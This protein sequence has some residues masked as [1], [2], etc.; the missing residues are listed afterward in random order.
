MKI[1][2]IIILL[3][4][5][6]S[7][8]FAQNWLDFK[9]PE[10]IKDGSGYSNFDQ[11]FG[12]FEDNQGNLYHTGYFD[13]EITF[14]TSTLVSKGG[15]DIFVAKVNKDGG[16]LWAVSAGG[17]STDFARDIACDNSGNIFITGYFYGTCYF[18]MIELSSQA[19]SDVFVA[20]INSNGE[21]QW[22]KSGNGSGFNRAN[23]ITCDN[24]G[25]AY[26]TGSFEANITFGNTTLS[27]SGNRDIFVVK[28]NSNGNFDWV[29]KAGGS[30]QDES[31]S[32][33]YNINNSFAMITGYFSTTAN[34]GNLSVVSAGGRDVYVARIGSN[35]TWAW[36]ANVGTSGSEEARAIAVDGSGNGIV[37][38]FYT[39]AIAFGAN[40]LPQGTERDIFVAKID[41]DGAWNWAA[42]GFGAGNDEPNSI[43]VDNNGNAYVV[44][45]F[46]DKVN[47][48]NTELTSTADRN[49]FVAR[50][51][52]SG[53]WSWGRAATGNSTIE[54]GG[55]SVSSTG[56]CC[57]SGSFYSN[58][59]I[60]NNTYNTLGESDIFVA[61]IAANGTWAWG[62]TKGG[63][64]GIT[65]GDGIAIDSIGNIIYTGSFFGKIKIGNTTLTSNGN[66]DIYLA[67]YSVDNGWLW[68]K[69]F[70]GIN[71]D[72]AKSI[73]TD[74]D[75]NIYLTG[76]FENSIA[77]GSQNLTSL[78][79][80]DAFIA[81]FD[82]QG[83]CIWANSIG[84]EDNDFGSEVILRDDF[85][86]IS[87]VYTNRPY[88]GLTRLTNRGNEDVYLS[89]MSLDGDYEWA[90]SLGSS[91]YETVNDLT[92]DAD[93][94]I[95]ITG[96]FE[97]NC[98]FGNI[99]TSSKGGDDVYI[100][101]ASS[102]GQW[103]W[104]VGA[105]SESFQESGWG[106]TTDN[107]KNVY[108]TGT[109]RGF[110]LF[111]GEYL[112]SN[113]Q[114][115]VFITKL[116]S[117]GNWIWNKGFGSTGIDYSYGLKQVNERLTLIGAVSSSFSVDNQLFI[118]NGNTRNAF[119]AN[120]NL[121]GVMQ[122]VR[123]DENSGVSEIKDLVV[124]PQGMS[125][126][127]G[128]YIEKVKFSN[129]ISTESNSIDNNA[130]FAIN[131]FIPPKPDWDHRDSTGKSS[132]VHIPRNINPKVNDRNLIV[133][134]AV[135]VF[136]SRNNN[137]YCAGMSYFDGNDM[138][139]T[140]WGDDHNTPV[141]DGFTDDEKYTFKVWDV[142]NAEEI[143]YNV[144]YASG[145]DKFANTAV[146]EL[147][148]LP[149]VYDTLRIP[150]NQGW[151]MVSSYV[152]PKSTNIDSVF[153]D[154]KSKITLVKNGAG[155]TYIP[156]YQINNIGSWN[157]LNGYQIHAKQSTEII[158]LGD[159][160][161]PENT[162]FNLS[163]GW[164]MISFTRN[165]QMNC[166]IAFQSLVQEGK[167][168]LAK[169]GSGLNFIPQYGI[170][171]IGNLKPGQGYQIYLNAPATFSFP[172]ND[173]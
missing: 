68:A 115:D 23:S 151:N 44:G 56:V 87:G 92:F 84:A 124:T 94:N 138:Q 99:I 139:I 122:W 104:S 35:G 112:I 75:N 102:N 72:G 97:G 121:S 5:A 148:Q 81:K 146:S 32:I 65:T 21:W 119:I 157:I 10:I 135:G 88:L 96:G 170:N 39:N 67:K 82:S 15:R 76:N 172:E 163:S 105:G 59:I 7:T 111:G 77:F 142:L 147:L 69:S 4:I 8:S 80:S 134:D 141:K 173:D 123:S 128:N 164:S 42:R 6:S 166:E 106:I 144:R 156:D 43:G 79:M 2:K 83:D 168:V 74:G 40:N 114:T 169:S 61:R 129:Y 51:T 162:Q 9:K 49:F 58:I 31:L 90:I 160:V 63:V 22:A 98:Y 54:A 57:L 130:F 167:L 18:G 140:I 89:K 95:L 38:G 33:K 20:K 143:T 131:G 55:I 117:S 48:G 154:I 27:T 107:D 125:Y 171:T 16:W 70:G 137:L 28:V 64:T 108:V 93:D 25:N 34:F 45:S 11:S 1:V 24:L 60:N 159:I 126:L 26:I 53:V 37:T 136:Y 17:T 155:L 118:S 86:I 52:N 78:G 12:I 158:I 116:D 85:I 161:Q 73:V 62:Q 91:Q 103:I 19:S 36:V 101:K 29:V 165:S 153:N 109:F 152:L 132:I 100:A 14:G 30:G 3:V 47:F 41:K 150:L 66:T 110:A 133:G 127:I 46:L 113:G 120:L 149:I 13:G 71:A 145:P 50:I